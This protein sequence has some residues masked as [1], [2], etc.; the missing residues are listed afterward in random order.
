MELEQSSLWREYS[1]VVDDGA[2]PVHYMLTAKVLIGEDTIVPLKVMSV[3]FE[4]DFLNNY[5]EDFRITMV[6]GAGTYA[7]RVYPYLTNIDIELTFTPIGE[8]D[9]AADENQGIKSERYTAVLIDTGNPIVE[10]NSRNTPDEESLNLSALY[11]VTFQLVNKSVEKLRA[12]MVGGIY[13]NMTV[14]KFLKGL[15]TTASQSIK[16]DKSRLLKGVDMVTASNQLP[17][18]QIV[19]KHGL[20]LVHLPHYVQHHCGGVYSAGMGYY[21][22]KDHWYLFPCFDVTRFNA[23]EKTLT[24]INLPPNRAPGLERT[25]RLNGDNLVIVSTGDVSYR[26]Q[27]NTEQLNQGNGVRFTDANKLIEGFTTNEGN[28]A[29]ASRGAINNEFLAQKRDSGLNIVTNGRKSIT[30]NPYVEYSALARRQGSLITLVWEHANRD[31]LYPGMPVKI[32]YLDGDEIKTL[33]GVLLK[34]HTYIAASEPG[35]TGR[36]HITNTMLGVFVKPL[37]V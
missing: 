13:N 36:R 29:I 23:T 33:M 11:D 18:Q 12:V 5:A 32:M 16:L 19:I 6:M 20:P 15:M 1:A 37:S 26:D 25:Y 24:V 4:E 31:L 17:R 34:I 7:K 10:M 14:E 30:A 2:K 8:T 22:Q 21:L 3:D 9:T 35:L 28:K 27:S